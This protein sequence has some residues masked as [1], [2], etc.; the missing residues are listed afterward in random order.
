MTF[1]KRFVPQKAA[2][3]ATTHR[4]AICGACEFK[5]IIPVLNRDVCGACGCPILS[6]TELANSKCPKGKW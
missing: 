2:S 3:E 6:K 1:L 4:R 5:K